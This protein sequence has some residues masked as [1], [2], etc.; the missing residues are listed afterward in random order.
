MGLSQGV[1]FTGT[2]TQAAA[3]GS[4]PEALW[5]TNG[6]GVTE[7]QDFDNPLRQ[8]FGTVTSSY[9]SLDGASLP[10]SLLVG[11]DTVKGSTLYVTDPAT[12]LPRPLAVP[13]LATTDLL[14]PDGHA[15]TPALSGLTSVGRIVLFSATDTTGAQDLWRSDG[16]AAGTTVVPVAGAGT[17]FV[18]GSSPMTGID[19]RNI[20]AFGGGALFVAN[21]ADDPFDLFFTDGTA[22]GTRESAAF[23]LAATDLGTSFQPLGVLDGREIFEG[24]GPDP[25][26]VG[27]YATDGTA[28][29]TVAL[30]I[31]VAAGSSAVAGGR[32]LYAAAVGSTG[33]HATDGT[34][35]GTTEILSAGSFGS[36]ASLGATAVFGDIAQGGSLWVSDGTAAGTHRVAVA[37]LPPGASLSPG[38]LTSFG[39]RALF[40]APDTVA[41]GGSDSGLW[42]TDG[43]A[44]GTLEIAPGVAPDRIV[45]LPDGQ[46]CFSGTGGLYVTDGTA[47]GTRLVPGTAAL[48]P[49]FVTPVPSPLGFTGTQAQYALAPADSGALQARDLSVP[50]SATLSVPD[51]RV[52]TFGDGSTAVL[53]PTGNAEDIARFYLAAYGRA[54]D[55]AGLLSYAGQL[56][57]G[58]VPLGRIADA[59]AGSAEFAADH[60]APTNAQ[61][62][63]LLYG[64]ADGRAPDPGGLAAYTAA[65][66][67]GQTRGQVLLAIA[68]GAEARVHSQAVAGSAGVATVARLY[69]AIDGRAP[70][71]GGLT[72]YVSALDGGRSVSQIAAAML[73]G[74]EYAGRFGSPDNGAFVT[75]LYRNLLGRAPD[76]GGLGAYTA[77]LNAGEGRASLVAG[78][79]GGD[80]ARLATAGITHEGIVSIH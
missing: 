67:G 53:D 29:G 15:I 28:A 80:E 62:V 3:A 6:N 35:A 72:N 44:A 25:S 64:D 40:S 76:S 55:L 26:Q 61:F 75:E 47:A 57:A 23:P 63:T 11:L 69:E 34:A 41:N 33:L 10:G 12:G 54:P 14:A 79:I 43:T 45:A 51:A 70:D 58:T 20:T 1:V 27:L 31:T 46:A 49:D 56:D 68:E 8:V 9:Y 16:T 38:D 4:E 60:G 73:A 37:G 36:L 65:L 21:G 42:V 78:F 2:G 77:A 59:A 48:R 71:P 7:A 32:L 5:V 22:A 18:I 24:A 50:E 30:G 19:A 74:P 17:S 13:G 39:A 52:M 66:A